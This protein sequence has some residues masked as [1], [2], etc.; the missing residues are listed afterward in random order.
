MELKKGLT[1]SSSD[2]FYDLCEGYLKPEVMCSSPEDA[3]R[4]A[5]SLVVIQDFQKSC[6]EQIEGFI[7]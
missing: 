3:K 6:E 2:F 5:D 4:V 1:E 7:Q